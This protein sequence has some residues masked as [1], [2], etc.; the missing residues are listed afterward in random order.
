MRARIIAAIA[1]LGAADGWY[2]YW[3]LDPGRQNAGQLLSTVVIMLGGFTVM[4]G[5]VIA[6]DRRRA[7]P[8]RPASARDVSALVDDAGRES[9]PA[10]DPPGWTLGEDRDRK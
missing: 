8:K 9:F 2:A 10:S 1:A 6:I 7:G 3:F 4:A 5:L